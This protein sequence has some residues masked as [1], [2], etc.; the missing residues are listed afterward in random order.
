MKNIEGRVTPC[1]KG[2]TEKAR[3]Y[4]IWTGDFYVNK[5]WCSGCHDELVMHDPSYMYAAE[6][7]KGRITYCSGIRERWDYQ[8][9]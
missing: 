9:D 5:K 4:E 3:A 1:D 7:T 2:R 8:A 6:V